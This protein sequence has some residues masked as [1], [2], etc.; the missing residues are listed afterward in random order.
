MDIARLLMEGQPTKQIAANLGIG[1]E[2][3]LWYR[4]RLYA[5]LNV[6]SAAAFTSEMH[7]LHLV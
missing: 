3:V 4:K 6:H 2:T 7:R 1:D 5:K